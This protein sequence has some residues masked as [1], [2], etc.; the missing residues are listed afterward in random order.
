[1]MYHHVN[2]DK[3]TN[4]LDMF[5][6]HLE[7]ISNNFASIFPTKERIEKNSICLVFDD[8]YADFYFYIFPLLKKYKLK[9]LLAV[10][11]KYILDSTKETSSVRLGFKHDVLFENYHKA[12][13]CTFKELKEMSYSG[14]VRIC[15]HS[16]SHENMLKESLDIDK[17]ITLSKDILEEKLKISVDTFVFPFGKYSKDILKKV[18]R[19]YSFSFRI[20]NAIH[21]DFYGI[22]GVNYRVKGDNLKYPNEPFTFKKILQYRFKAMAKR[23][24]NG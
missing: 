21:K 11:T 13:F 14:L 24:S 20:G 4:S 22:N 5:D 15:S 1:M 10:P 12:T 3:L 6:K 19:V 9:A 16:H 17:E 8:A 2:S 23:L 18:D 7:Y